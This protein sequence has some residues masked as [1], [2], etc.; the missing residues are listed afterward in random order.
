M[1]KK[2]TR[3]FVFHSYPQQNYVTVQQIYNV[4]KEVSLFLLFICLC[5]NHFVSL[6]IHFQWSLRFPTLFWPCG[7]LFLTSNDKFFIIKFMSIDI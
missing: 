2:I 5:I 1:E 7:S 3:S 4:K 6:F